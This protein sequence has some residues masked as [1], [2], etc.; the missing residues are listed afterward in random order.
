MGL[1]RKAKQMVYNDCFQST[2][3]P[4]L[5]VSPHFPLKITCLETI[6]TAPKTRADWPCEITQGNSAAD[7]MVALW[8]HNLAWK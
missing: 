8:F 3:V 7:E 4:K 2:I 1:V 5:A 6:L